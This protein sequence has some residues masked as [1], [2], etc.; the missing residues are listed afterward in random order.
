MNVVIFPRRIYYFL[1]VF[2]VLSIY[3]LPG[4][5]PKPPGAPENGKRGTSAPSGVTGSGGPSTPGQNGWFGFNPAVESSGSG[6]PRIED[7]RDVSHNIPGGTQVNPGSE[8]WKARVMGSQ[9]AATTKTAKLK[10]G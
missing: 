7:R 8:D 5:G 2:A 3:V 1:H 4:L 6:S 10:T 9:E